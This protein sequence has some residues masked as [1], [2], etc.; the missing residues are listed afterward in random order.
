MLLLMMMMMI[1]III[2]NKFRGRDHY[3]SSYKMDKQQE[4]TKDMD[5][6]K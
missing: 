5:H 1:I 6:I 3:P 2:M 4:V